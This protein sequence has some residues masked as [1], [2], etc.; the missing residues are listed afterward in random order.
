MA[1]KQK[2][3]KSKQDLILRLE[4]TRQM[5]ALRRYNRWLRLFGR[6]GDPCV[7]GAELYRR[8]LNRW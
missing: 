5:N 2:R 4:T 8:S 1:K 3:R 6:Y 7:L